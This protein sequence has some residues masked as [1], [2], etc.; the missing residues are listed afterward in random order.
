MARVLVVD[1]SELQR[2]SIETI[3]RGIGHEVVLA[4]DGNE[5]L[6]VFKNGGID[7]ILAD[8]NMPVLTG[9]EMCQEIMKI[10]AGSPPPILMVTTEVGSADEKAAAKKV[11]VKAWIIKPYRDDAVAKVV[12]K[13]LA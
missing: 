4:N 11:G 1:D 9:L 5:G 6:T 2:R 12:E 3:V 10:T 7:L 13:L 8:H